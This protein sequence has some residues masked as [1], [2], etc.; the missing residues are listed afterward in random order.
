VVTRLGHAVQK[1]RDV[2]TEQGQPAPIERL[3]ELRFRVRQQKHERHS[4]LNVDRRLSK[5]RRRVGKLGN[6]VDLLTTYRVLTDAM[7]R[8]GLSAVA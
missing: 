5:R 2:Q 1:D 7:S 8:Q 3:A 4:G 6:S